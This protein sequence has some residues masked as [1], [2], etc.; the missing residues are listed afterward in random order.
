VSGA[1]AWVAAVRPRTL[2]AAIVPVIVGTAV[3]ARAGAARPGI[4]VVAL[5][6]ALLLQIGTNLVNDWGDGRRGADGPDRLGPPRAVQSGWLTP[7]QVLAGGALAL[8]VASVLGIGLIA[9]GGWPIAAIGI[10]GVVAAVAYTAGPAP[11]AYHG[12]GEVTVFL[13]F[14]PLAV[15]GTELVQA[16]VVGGDAMLASVAVGLLAVAILLV[17]NVRDAD[18]DR[19]TGKQTLVVRLGRQAGR[20]AYA[21]AL[22]V[23]FLAATA[24]GFARPT[25]LLVWLA[26]PLAVAPLAAMRRRTDGPAL[27]AALVATARLHLAFGLLLAAGLAW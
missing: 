10:A 15:C 18:S 8:A 7:N 24:I 9:R 14:G 26:A 22:A 4:A 12:L 11:L 23:A 17:N 3:A 21:G 25:V 1:R 16:G 27:N 20:T 13:F 6:A 5:A 19:R 2:S